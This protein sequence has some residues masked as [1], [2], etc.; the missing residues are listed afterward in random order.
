MPHGFRSALIHTAL[1][2]GRREG[3]LQARILLNML[4][5]IKPQDNSPSI[6]GDFHALQDHASALGTEACNPL[7]TMSVLHHQRH[8]QRIALPDGIALRQRC[9]E[10]IQRIG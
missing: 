4:A 6:L 10:H 1:H 8:I 3:Q 9:V 2:Q 5:F 7:G